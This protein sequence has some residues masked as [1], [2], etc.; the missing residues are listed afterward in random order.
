MSISDE[1]FLQEL[2]AAFQI[3]AGE[4]LQSMSTGLLEMEKDPSAPAHAPL[5][6]TICREAHSLKG[7]ARAVNVMDVETICQALED[8]FSAWKYKTLLP[9]ASQFD[10]LYQSL[11]AIEK[12]LTIPAGTTVDVTS[13][14]TPTQ[15][16]QKLKA[17]Q[18]KVSQNTAS[19]QLSVVQ[20]PATQASLTYQASPITEAPSQPK[21]E[22]TPLFA[23]PPV[24]VLQQSVPTLTPTAREPIP[25]HAPPLAPS[26][27]VV[28]QPKIERRPEQRSAPAP[29]KAALAETVR[30][31]THKLD[32]LLL[33]AEEM[34]SV[35]LMAG[36]HAEDLRDARSGFEQWKKEWR[37]IAP[38][39]RRVRRAMESRAQENSDSASTVNYGPVASLL[40]F[41]E[42][43]QTY[44]KTLENQLAILSRVAERD[45]RAAGAL[46]NN[47][48]DD[49]KK[50]LMMPFS[51]LLG[52]FP[53][54]VRDLARDEG[55]DV[56]FSVQGGEIEIDKRI[57]EEIKDP[58][59]HLLRN[60]VDHGIE[61]PDE[62]ERR[63]KPRRAT[64]AVTIE[65]TGGSEVA[66]L[67]TDDGAGLDAEK[68]RAAAIK[69]G[70]L[71]ADDA[72]RLNEAQTRSL[73]FHS[74][75]STSPI[76]TEISGRG[77][78]MAIVSEKV[79]KLGGS[80]AVESRTGEGTTFRISLPLTLATFKGILVQAAGQ[81]FVIPTADV[82]RVVRIQTIE[83]QTVENR[84]TI[85]LSRAAEGQD[86]TSL[87]WLEDVLELR[88]P[89]KTLSQK[90][91]NF[92]QVVVLGKGEKRV[93]F[94]VDGVLNE[95]EVL[96]KSLGDPLSRVRNVSGA[97]VLGSGKAVPILNCSDLLKSARH[98]SRASQ[99]DAAVGQTAQRRTVLVAED[100]ITSRM[101]LKNILES[102]GYQVK[103]AV[104]GMEALTTLKTEEFD[105]V[106]SDVD[107]PRM[108]GFDLTAAIRSDKKLAETPVVLVTGRE[109][110]EDR[111]RGID[112]G[113]NAY[114]VK[115]SFDQSNLLEV[116]RR[117]I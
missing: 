88:G 1:A 76:I 85:A 112:V 19:N 92:L 38:P 73:I 18:G 41:L 56:E 31:S 32:A 66:L 50:L 11:D 3:E 65:R 64:V 42:W 83:I 45:Q 113:A 117:L 30:I 90:A 6:E 91:S 103:T 12:S 5:I 110:R 28:E 96:V 25:A 97:T 40:D 46:V 111:E 77:L 69:H 15:I 33:Q 61:A 94:V 71:T 105:A 4:H 17:I 44:V 107:M 95:Q 116:I 93:A 22:T 13:S 108:S 54:V 82:E 60:C 43:N 49:T 9:A 74:G 80:I 99:T 10:T 53:K 36:Q 62:R 47:L 114:L 70:A 27:P 34:L 106:V 21:P 75:V 59:I 84:D 68:I 7:A 52:I 63:G 55:K 35:K 16:V 37:K 78:G 81:I 109:S 100:S 26:P 14:D 57:L 72:A 101:L 20:S 115:S 79:E 8:V 104:D 29:D 39:L 89:A 51:T 67:I 23:V 102:A 48:L 86:L 2:R 24:P 58:L 87:V 98:V